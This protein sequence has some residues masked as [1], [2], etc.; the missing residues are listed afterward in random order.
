MSVILIPSKRI[1]D[2]NNNKV[3]DNK[4]ANFEWACYNMSSSYSN[5]FSKSFKIYSKKKYQTA[6]RIGSFENKWDENFLSSDSS[7][8]VPLTPSTD[9]IYFIPNGEND[10]PAAYCW[11]GDSSTSLDGSG[12]YVLVYGEWNNKNYVV[13]DTSEWYDKTAFTDDINLAVTIGKL[14]DNSD[15]KQQV[16]NSSSYVY[17]ATY[18]IDD[19]TKNFYRLIYD[20]E[21]KYLYFSKKASLPSEMKYS[22]NVDAYFVD[23]NSKLDGMGGDD[24]ISP[25]KCN[26]GQFMVYNIQ[27]DRN[28]SYNLN[29]YSNKKLVAEIK[30]KSAYPDENT[31]IKFT[32][33]IYS[34]IQNTAQEHFYYFTVAR[35]EEEKQNFANSFFKDGKIPTSPQDVALDSNKVLSSAKDIRVACCVCDIEEDYNIIILVKTQGYFKRTYSSTADSTGNNRVWASDLEL[36]IKCEN[37]NKEDY[38]NQSNSD[39]FSNEISELDQ[40]NSYFVKNYESDINEA[41]KNGK[42]TA[43]IK[44]S[45]NDY[46][47]SDGNVVISKKDQTKKITFDIG[48]I[49]IPYVLSPKGDIPMSTNLDGSAKKFLVTGV[50]LESDGVLWQNLTLQETDID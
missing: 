30:I 5:I 25:I 1:Y 21:K 27:Y 4:I 44:C 7:S 8:T 22:G 45:I 26:D 14:Y 49:V 29:N 11:D 33:S 50:G 20:G 9:T 31:N 13:I 36:T 40:K 39:V 46:L 16:L 23:Y 18:Q 28:M 32:N 6:Y 15:M 48:D 38:R 47:D 12:R 37:I 34:S 42:E 2:K 35:N 10:Q 24:Y 41:Y 3:V 19:S 43:T 17:N